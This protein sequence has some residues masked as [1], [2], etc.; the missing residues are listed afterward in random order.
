MSFIHFSRTWHHLLE[1]ILPN[2]F[3]KMIKV[4]L[5]LLKLKMNPSLEDVDKQLTREIQRVKTYK[6]NLLALADTK[7]KAMMDER[8]NLLRFGTI[9]VEDLDDIIEILKNYN[10]A[11]PQDKQYV[12]DTFAQLSSVTI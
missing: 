6:K 10:T 4:I 2:D 7:K 5:S 12:I 8:K 11:S 9:S 1:K 3:N